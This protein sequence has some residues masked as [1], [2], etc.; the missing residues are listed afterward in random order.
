MKL[1]ASFERNYTV[2]QVDTDRKI[3]FFVKGVSST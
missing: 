2:E 3:R 1:G